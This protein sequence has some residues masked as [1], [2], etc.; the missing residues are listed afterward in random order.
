MAVAVLTVW[1]LVNKINKPQQPMSTINERTIALPEPRK[2]SDFSLEQAIL[3]RESVRSYQNEPL[4]LQEISQLLWA[5][6]GTRDSSGKRVVPSAGALYPLEV[7]IIGEIEGIKA[8]MY[9][10]LPD[11]H[12]ITWVQEA[13]F[14]K[15][16]P[17]SA[18]DQDYLAKAPV[19]LLIIGIYERTTGKYGDQ[20]VRYVHM[21]AGHASQNVYLQATALGLG[22]VT[23]GG[24]DSAAVKSLVGLPDNEDPLYLMPVGRLK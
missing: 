2:N 12:V 19:V 18:Y 23:V 15:D 4:T 17:A 14:K 24:F 16:L 22:T 13:D 10:Y 6:Q 11:D 8:G 20:G 7:Y 9:H 5:A 21:E 3:R 1:Y